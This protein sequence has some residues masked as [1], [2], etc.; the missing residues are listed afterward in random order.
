[1]A[2]GRVRAAVIGCG[3]VS[4]VHFDALADMADVELVAVSDTDASAAQ[5]AAARH[6]APAYSDHRALIEAA[7]PDVV[8]I[9]T[10]HSQHASVAVDALERGVNVILEKP[11]A[12]DLAAG[13]AIIE[14]AQR[15][16]A[17]LGVCFQNRYNPTSVRLHDALASGEFGDVIGARAQVMWTRTAD[18]YKAKPWR[19][20]WSGSGG[21]LMMNQAVHTVDLVQWLVGD[22]ADVSGSA[23]TLLFADTIEVEDTASAVLRHANGVRTNFY[24]TLTHFTNAPVLIEVTCT[25]AVLRLEGDLRALRADGTVEVLAQA[26]VVRTA[27][28]YWGASH[29]RLIADFYSGLGASGPFWI[30]AAEAYKSLA[31]VQS[32][33]GRPS[34]G[35]QS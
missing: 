33:Y 5:A 29:S 17:R 31:I 18:Y 30:D 1:M 23:S 13:R 28:N 7:R 14:A 34:E 22:V 27:R 16:D 8:H 32:I 6:G 21:G 3:D 19:G 26:D 20:T 24:A 15:S 25:D 9:C 10:P 12:H 2:D 35:S 11:L 4:S